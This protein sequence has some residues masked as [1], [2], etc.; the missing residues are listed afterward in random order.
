MRIQGYCLLIGCMGI[1]FF[2][3]MGHAKELLTEEKVRVFYDE[4]FAVQMKSIDETLAFYNKHT[5]K[6]IKA[7]LNLVSRVKGMATEK[8]VFE[9]DKAKLLTETKRG[10]DISQLK[11]V[12]GNVI[13]VRISQDGQS[14]KVKSSFVSLSTSRIPVEG[15][16][17]TVDIEQSALCDDDIVLSE[18]D[19]IMTT[20]STCNA[21]SMINLPE[22]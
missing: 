5:H 17:I 6:D 13:S 12:E 20:K 2:P 4:S 14:A 18:G 1:A 9:Y 3:A 8:Q 11:S 22:K 15:K 21:E 19:V 16:L 10:H 7:T